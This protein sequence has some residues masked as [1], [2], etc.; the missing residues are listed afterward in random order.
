[1][2]KVLER[3]SPGL[4]FP[5]NEVPVLSMAIGLGAE[6]Q[7]PGFFAHPPIPLPTAST[8]LDWTCKSPKISRGN[9]R[10][11]RVRFDRDPHPRLESGLRSEIR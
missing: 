5:C 4:A 1:M 10:I 9:I 3:C 6:Q 11:V 8:L 2:S 7:R